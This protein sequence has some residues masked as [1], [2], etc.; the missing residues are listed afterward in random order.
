[1]ERPGNTIG[2]LY[3]VRDDSENS[4]VGHCWMAG[5]LRKGDLLLCIEHSG[6]CFNNYVLCELHT[7]AIRALHGSKFGAYVFGDPLVEE[8]TAREFHLLMAGE[9]VALTEGRAK[10]IDG[11]GHYA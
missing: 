2:A 7:N 5:R 9:S 11:D 4:R 8:L 6:D 10:L 3:R 1:M